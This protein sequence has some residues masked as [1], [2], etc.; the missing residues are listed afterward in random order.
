MDYLDELNELD[1]ER[2]ASDIE[3]MSKMDEGEIYEIIGNSLKREGYSVVKKARPRKAAGKAKAARKAR[4]FDIIQPNMMFDDKRKNISPL[5]AMKFVN[6]P[7]LPE[8]D[9]A[10]DEGRRFWDRFKDQ[11][12]KTICNDE[13]IKTLL[14]GKGTLK[15]YLVVGIPI[16]LSAL[17]IG[18]LS[19]VMLVVVASVFALIL[20]VGFEAYCELA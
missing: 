10:R 4:G 18:A 14:T 15:D 17:G 19:P 3:E 16:V 5:K 1:F 7:L 20:K 13:K 12:R 9:S 6:E 11:L 2:I 8:T